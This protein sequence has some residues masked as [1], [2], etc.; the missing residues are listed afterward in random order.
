MADGSDP[1]DRP[2]RLWASVAILSV[3]G[4]SLLFGFVLLPVMQGR[5]AGVDAFEAICRAL[6]ITPGS[7]SGRQPVTEA[8]AQPTTRVAWSADLMNALAKPSAAGESLAGGCAACHGR[9]GRATD[10]GAYPDLAGQSAA[11]IYKQLHDF[12]TGSRRSA[13]MTPLMQSL[14]DEQMVAV[15][16]HF[17]AFP[18]R[19]LPAAQL[20]APAPTIE[21][22]AARGDPVRRIP[23]CNACHGDQSGGPTEAPRLSRQSREYLAAQLHAFKKGERRNDIYSRMRSVAIPLTDDEIEGLAL[24]YAATRTY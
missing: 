13:V 7:P 20:P 15:A 4:F 5:A 22:L 9:D 2:W 21:Q 17:A 1:L 16:A 19:S 11:A 23:A 6:G 18:A 8:K 24:F 3:F 14:T 12:K 10:V